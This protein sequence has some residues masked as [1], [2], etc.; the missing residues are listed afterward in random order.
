MAEVDTSSYTNQPALPSALDTLQ[1]FQ[2]AEIQHQNIQ[3]NKIAIDQSKLKLLNDH[4][5]IMNNEL[6]TMVN[7]PD[8]TKEKVLGRLNSVADM[9]HMPNEVRAKMVEEF[10]PL[11]TKEQ[12]LKHLD[13]TLKRSMTTQEKLNANI[14]APS[15]Y[16]NGQADIPMR[17]GMRGGPFPVGAPIQHQLPPDT[18][19]TGPGGT[20]AIGAQEPQVPAGAVPVPGGLPGQY[21]MPGSLP[22]GPPPVGSAPVG[23]PVMPVP[24]LPVAPP[25]APVPPAVAARMKAA[26]GMANLPVDPVEAPLIVPRGPMQSQSPN[27]EAGRNMY[28]ED[29][30]TATSKLTQ[31]KP[32]EQAL[33][34]MPELSGS[35]IGTEPFNKIR[36]AAIN[37]GVIKADEKDPTVV[38]QEVNKKLSQYVSQNGSRSDASLAQAEN[39]NPDVKHQVLPALIKLTRDTIA[40][41]RIIA[42]RANAF[43]DEKDYSKYIKHSAKFPQEMDPRAFQL[44]LMAPEE[45]TKLLKSEQ[46]K[47]AKGNKKAIQ[48]FNSLQIADKQGFMNVEE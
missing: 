47:A 16:N 13:F 6:A 14:G 9:L 2:G 8:V 22:V 37:L 35:G 32:M 11:I 39:S 12:V 27:F 20:R 10:A 7:D 26:P 33:K 17:Q 15:I 43:G 18:T 48:F 36:A 19:Q 3:S 40:Q 1:K 4:F 29:Q 45:R 5:N 28:V 24:R 38:Y 42:A 25:E 41:D 21:T 23:R 46:T 44:D 34:I 30:K 31:L